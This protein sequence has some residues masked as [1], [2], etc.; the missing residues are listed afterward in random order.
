MEKLPYLLVGIGAFLVV[1][2]LIV[3]FIVDSFSSEPSGN[4]S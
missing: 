1:A 3:L 2:G 4:R